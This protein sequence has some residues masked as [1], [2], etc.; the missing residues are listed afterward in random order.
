VTVAL[1]NAERQRR[2]R[3]RH[4]GEAS[5]KAADLLKQLI[6]DF[7]KEHDYVENLLR[8]FAGRAEEMKKEL[9]ASQS[10]LAAGIAQLKALAELEE[11]VKK[12]RDA[13]RTRR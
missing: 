5:R 9:A 12:R 7:V 6:A 3:K 11:K 10:H 13:R 4:Y 1:S 2:W 8:G